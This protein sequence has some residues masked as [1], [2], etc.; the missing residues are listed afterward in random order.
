[1]PNAYVTTLPHASIKA[2]LWADAP[3]PPVRP[4]P[5]K[6]QKKKKAAPRPV[7]LGDP[8]LQQ[9]APSDIGDEGVIPLMPPV[10]PIKVP[11]PQ[12]A[13]ERKVLEMQQ[14]PLRAP[15]ASDPPPPS[16]PS[17]ASA[18]GMTGILPDASAPAEL[19]ANSLAPT[20]LAPSGEAVVEARPSALHYLTTASDEGRHILARSPRLA[21]NGTTFQKCTPVPKQVVLPTARTVDREVEEAFA[22]KKAEKERRK[23]ERD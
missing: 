22:L 13:L 8:A 18:R 16:R 6:Q 11:A 1:M 23:L 15:P 2:R 19:D 5:R 3:P 9:R 7:L 14:Q 12:A 10:F 20:T 17:S 21:R 4:S